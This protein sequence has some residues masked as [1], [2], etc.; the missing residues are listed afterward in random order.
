M[1]KR[2]NTTTTKPKRSAMKIVEYFFEFLMVEWIENWNIKEKEVEL[3]KVR[4]FVFPIEKLVTVLMNV[5]VNVL[6]SVLVIFFGKK[7]CNDPS[8]NHFYYFIL[9]N[10]NHVKVKFLITYIGR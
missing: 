3:E 2:E 5:L 10:F 6:K 9:L 7:K 1:V 4:E 8:K